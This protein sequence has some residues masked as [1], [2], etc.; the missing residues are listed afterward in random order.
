IE[1]VFCTK[2]TCGEIAMPCENYREALI[3]AAAADTSPS[4]ELRLHLD[5]CTSCRAAL[6]EEQQL[7]ATIDT[8]LRATANAEVPASFLYRVGARIQ[9]A[10]VSPRR[11][12][13]SL[14]L[15]LVGAATVV[16]IFIGARPRHSVID[17]QANQIPATIA[18]EKLA[19]ST[20]REAPES[21]VVVASTRAHPV[22]RIGHVKTSSSASSSHLEVLVPPDEREA[23]ARFV[24][25]QQVRSDVVV[26]VVAPTPDDEDKRPSVK[27]LQ[28]AK[29]VVI[30][31]EQL[32][33]AVPD[34]AQEEQ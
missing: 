12:R 7:F 2:A 23:Y 13:P 18:H 33:S 27:P 24:T 19:T 10:S 11:W 28:I 21:P 9:E 25:A 8:G 34:R 22:Q 26:A 17:N 4:G 5:A 16:A 32:A 31:L 20:R 30:P 6:A 15:A 29:L 3:E 1:I 14:I